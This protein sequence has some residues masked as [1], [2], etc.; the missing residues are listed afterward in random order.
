MI[1]KNFPTIRELYK[2]HGKTINFLGVILSNLNV[3][4]DPK[5]K[6]LQ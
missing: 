1:F 6:D 5:K 3:A 4:L 2:E